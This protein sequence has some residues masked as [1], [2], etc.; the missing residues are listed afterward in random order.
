VYFSRQQQRKRRHVFQ[1]EGGA[2]EGARGGYPW[3][4]IRGGIRGGDGRG[5][6]VGGTS[7][8]KSAQGGVKGDG[9]DGV[10]GILAPLLGS[11]TFEGKL[12]GLSLR[13]F[14]EILYSHP[15]LHRAYC[16]PL[17][18]PMSIEAK[19]S[20]LPRY[21]DNQ[22]VPKMRGPLNASC[23]IISPIS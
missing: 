9:I 17:H 7:S 3:G 1:W 16:I 4:V 11:M 22:C 23:G 5:W 10:G 8:C 21:W 19:A 20:R 13:T 14:R 12:V 2:K 6:A 18:P 15:T